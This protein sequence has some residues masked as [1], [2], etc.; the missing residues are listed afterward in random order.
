MPD[1]DLTMAELRAVTGFAV[2]SAV[3]VL[4]FFETHRPEDDRPRAAL[5]AAAA[6]AGGDRR[7]RAQRVT[8]TAA[9]R[10]A[11]DSASPVAFH[12]AMAAGDAAASAYL[13][14]LADAV[15]VNHILR[16]SAHT[17]RVFELCPDE[18][19]CADDPAGHLADLATPL[20]I[21]VLCRYPRIDAGTTGV[22]LLVHE[23]D[24]RLR[25]RAES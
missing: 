20:L 1:F 11:K 22:G 17:L 14:P 23:L 3:Q 5:D 2:S 24:R 6:F 7:S 18:A 25:D 16:A 13:H 4:P 9:H 15:Q 21:A 12:A 19:P 10:A 8:A